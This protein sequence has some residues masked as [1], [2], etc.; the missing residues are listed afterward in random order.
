MR[1]S[2]FSIFKPIALSIVAIAV[3]GLGQGVV[4]ADEV[5]IAG[6]T[7]GCF[8]V[9]CVPGASSTLLGLTYNNS[10][11]DGTTAGGFLGIGA[12]PTP[13]INAD[14][15]GSLTLTDMAALYTGQTFTLR[16]TFTD[17]DGI[18][19]SDTANFTAVLTGQV[20]M[21]D[22]GGVTLDFNNTPILFTFNDT[23][24]GVT[25]IPGQQTTCGQ[26]SFLFRV[27]DVSIQAPETVGG[28]RVVPI[29][30]DILSAQQ[31]TI[32][33]PTSMLLL[34]TGLAGVAGAVRR[35][36]KACK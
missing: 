5:F 3:L 13:P 32:P 18:V 23:T 30:G 4:K 14:N 26:G 19:G 24:C 27:N 1:T 25:T 15:L 10:T 31:T 16:V 33:E 36:L 34:G 11:F 35:K 20:I 8:G 28:I 7:L 2:L 17:P 6:N 29:T 22:V 9:A 21:N 12:I